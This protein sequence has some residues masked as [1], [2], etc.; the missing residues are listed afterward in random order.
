MR[1]MQ[2][3]GGGSGSPESPGRHD[4]GPP[5]SLLGSQGRRLRGVC[6]DEARGEVR[7]TQVE[8][9]ESTPGRGTAW[10]KAERWA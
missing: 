4:R 3:L 6:I 10:T 7:A 2:A 5:T 8:R 9:R 1:E